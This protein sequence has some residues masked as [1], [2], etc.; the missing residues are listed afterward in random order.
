MD[1]HYLQELLRYDYE[2][3]WLEFKE[4]WFEPNELG[5]YISALSNSAAE[6]GRRFAYFIWG[7]TDETHEIVGTKFNPDRNVKNESLSHYLARQIYPYINFRFEEMDVNG[8]RIVILHIPAAQSVPTEFNKERY[9]RIGSSK[10]LLRKFPQK[11]AALWIKLQNI[12]KTIITT[13]APKQNLTF[14]KLLVYYMAKGLEL[15]ETTFADNLNFYVPNTKK[16]NL[17]H[18]L[19]LFRLN[20]LHLHHRQNQYNHL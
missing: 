5:E 12:E 11:E 16:Y 8:K 6:Y 9:I 10:E 7:V 17:L 20:N 4:N 1:L 14:S 2:K 19:I 18:Q 15:K 13:E 3:E